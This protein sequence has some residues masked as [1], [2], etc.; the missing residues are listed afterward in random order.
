MHRDTCRKS[1]PEK[2]RI[3]PDSERK[4]MQLL[5]GRSQEMKKD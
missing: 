4:G 2:V 3:N 5:P 1:L